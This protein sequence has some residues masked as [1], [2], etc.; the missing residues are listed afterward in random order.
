MRR[1]ISSSL[2]IHVRGSTVEMLVSS[3]M[4]NWCGADADPHLQS[5]EHLRTFMLSLKQAETTLQLT[6]SYIVRFV[7]VTFVR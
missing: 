6:F 5:W 7:F 2:L 4:H 1:K 3:V